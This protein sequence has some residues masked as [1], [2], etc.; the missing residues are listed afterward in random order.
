MLLSYLL[1]FL[2]FK[3][4][5]VPAIAVLEVAYEQRHILFLVDQAILA[6]MLHIGLTLILVK[7]GMWVS[8]TTWAQRL[9]I[10]FG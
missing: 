3:S 6:C 10:V 7:R 5:N 9:H 4:L 2:A 8:R 1:S